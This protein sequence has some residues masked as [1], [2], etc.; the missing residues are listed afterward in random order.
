MDELFARLEV[1]STAAA[2]RLLEGLVQRLLRLERLQPRVLGRGARLALDARRER[3]TIPAD[4]V[5]RELRA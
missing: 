2:P 3:A 4:A 1:F 5:R